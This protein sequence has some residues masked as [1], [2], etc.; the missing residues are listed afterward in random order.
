VNRLLEAQ[1][2]QE[3]RRQYTFA[4]A[5]IAPIV[6]RVIDELG[7]QAQAKNIRMEIESGRDLPEVFIDGEAVSE[8][9]ENLVDNAIK[10]SPVN[11]CIRVALRLVNGAVCV[12]V[13][14]QGI[15]IETDDLPRVFDRFY[16][17]RRGAT[18]RGTGLGL[19]LVKNTAEAH[20]GSV[21]VESEPDKGSR[22]LLQLPI[23]N[24]V[25]HGA[26]SD[27]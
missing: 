20:G 13:L 26:D 21:S 1:K 25:K 19:M 8:A 24:G 9:I 11:A 15:G 6:K 16:R 7:P 18:V 14:D 12:E 22:F 23:T 10:Y 4:A 27:S 3:G 5:T 2:I 17:G